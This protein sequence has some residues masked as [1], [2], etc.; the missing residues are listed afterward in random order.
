MSRDEMNSGSEAVDE[1]N[2]ERDS[3]LS[4]ESTESSAQGAFRSSPPLPN[5]DQTAIEEPSAMN[6]K[7]SH[8][9]IDIK[10][11]NMFASSATM[12][13]DPASSAVPPKPADQSNS[14]KPST[15]AQIMLP[16]PVPNSSMNAPFAT[17]PTS[18]QISLRP[19]LSKPG[20]AKPTLE[21]R[22]KAPS[23]EP[24]SSPE[25]DD[26]DGAPSGPHDQIKDFDWRD[27]DQRYHNKMNELDQQ[28]SD[29]LSEF[30]HL[31]QV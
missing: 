14:T 18:A 9:E 26:V 5:T 20:S 3:D 6:K 31:C 29:A 13:G 25:M 30:Q 28:E 11:E 12:V 27:L 17:T 23:P 10:D 24:E 2:K 19:E 7:R 21:H 8:D 15:S 22:Q 4:S 16:P 1:V